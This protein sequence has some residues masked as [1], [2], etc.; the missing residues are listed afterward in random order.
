MAMRRL[1]L[2]W[3][4]KFRCAGRGVAVGMHGQ[5][6]FIV[7]VVMAAIVLGLAWWLRLEAWRCAI[8]TL[9]VAGVLS[10]ELVNSS[11]ER[12]V[13]VVHPERHPEIGRALDIA[14]GAVLVM[15]IGAAVCGLIVLVPPLLQTLFGWP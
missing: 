3:C 7:H 11:L 5:D 15:A 2:R 4:D 14:A 13:L 12:I 6:S 10:L 9:C 8:V 1:V